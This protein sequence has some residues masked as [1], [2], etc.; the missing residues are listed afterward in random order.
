MDR[1]GEKTQIWSRES[2]PVSHRRHQLDWRKRMSDNVAYALV[3]YTTINIFAT[4]GAMKETGM[5]SLALLALVALVGAIIPACRWFERRWRD[6][7]DEAAA[8][9]E[10]SGDFRRD[11]IILWLLAVGL[12]FGLTAMFKAIA[13]AG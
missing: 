9:P 5:K 7:S 10:L 8:D 1:T 3:V 4:V 12:P 6:L 2:V 13:V 11:Q